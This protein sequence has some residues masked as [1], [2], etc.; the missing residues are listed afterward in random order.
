MKRL[1]KKCQYF[2]Q[3][4]GNFFLIFYSISRS[5]AKYYLHA[6]FPINW[7]I[8][9]EITEGEQNLPS[10]GHINLQKAQPA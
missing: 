1:L 6:K 5:V 9:T 2:E 4:P 8:Q 10:P 7:T 3:L